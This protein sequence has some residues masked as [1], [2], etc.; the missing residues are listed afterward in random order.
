MWFHAHNP[1]RKKPKFCMG[2]CRTHM[3]PLTYPLAE[4]VEMWFHAHIDTFH[5]NDRVHTYYHALISSAPHACKCGCSTPFLD[6][7]KKW[8][9]TH[10][11]ICCMHTFPC[12]LFHTF[13]LC[14]NTCFGILTLWRRQN[15]LPLPNLPFFLLSI[16][17]LLTASG[18][19]SELQAG[20]NFS[21]SRSSFSSRSR[22][23][24]AFR[25]VLS[26]I[27]CVV[28]WLSCAERCQ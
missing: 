1:V 11:Y 21:S 23:L 12:G 26:A 27:Q 18:V 22:G 6:C 5:P 4:E 17:S 7:L 3:Y 28:L 16:F 2:S 20:F 15:G 8:W 19:P 10:V 24:S 25:Q 13:T 14:S 9:G